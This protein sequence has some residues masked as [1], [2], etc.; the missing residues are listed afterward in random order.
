MDPG[1]KPGSVFFHLLTQGIPTEESYRPVKEGIEIDRKFLDRDGARISLGE[2]EQG[3]LIVIKTRVR[4]VSGP[5]KNVV[6]QT[7]LPSGLEV[8]NPRLETTETLP[9]MGKADLELAYLD[10]RDDRI[11]LFTDLSSNRWKTHYALVRAVTPGRF[12][13]PPL[14]VEAMYNPALRAS[15]EAGEI[16]I[17]LHG[18]RAQ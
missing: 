6:V 7:L 11:L 14:Q 15:G 17:R 3:D 4:S 12:R 10:L 18:A 2:L 13:L 1:F 8:E 9:W 16:Q 5:L